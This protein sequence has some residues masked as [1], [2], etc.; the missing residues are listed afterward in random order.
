MSNSSELTKEPGNYNPERE[1]SNPYDRARKEWDDRIGTVKKENYFLR[2]FLLIL[3]G[4]IVILALVIASMSGRSDIEPWL[5]TVNE[6]GLPI[7]VIPMKDV[8]VTP[9]QLQVGANLG[10]LIQWTRGVPA[11][12]VVIRKNW[13]NAYH[14]LAGKAAAKMTG[15]STKNPP[16]ERFQDETVAIEIISILPIS[17]STYQARWT[18]TVTLSN[19]KELPAETW[20]GTFTVEQGEAEKVEQLMVNPLSIFVIDYSWQREY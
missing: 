1:P 9:S 14:F 6:K 11:D 3:A 13:V 2:V 16:M 18:E 7:N 10:R 20:T 12:A 19:G 5:V 8:V 4:A 15:W 17:G